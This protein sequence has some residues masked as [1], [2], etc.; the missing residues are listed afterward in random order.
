M[1]AVEIDQER[2]VTAL[3]D[4]LAVVEHAAGGNVELL[5]QA[6]RAAVYQGR[7]LVASVL[8]DDE[9]LRDHTWEDASAGMLPQHVREWQTTWDE[10]NKP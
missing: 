9:Y 1:I 6:D 5:E 3:S 2:V 7:W 10:A 4:L 8:G